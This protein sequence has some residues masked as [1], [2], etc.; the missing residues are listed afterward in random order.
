MSIS[1][2]RII[3]YK[4]FTKNI[5]GSSV[6]LQVGEK[7]DDLSVSLNNQKTFNLWQN[8]MKN[9][10]DKL[11]PYCINENIISLSEQITKNCIRKWAAVEIDPECECKSESLKKLTLHGEYFG[12]IHS[13]T[14]MQFNKVLQEAMDYLINNNIQIDFNRSRLEIMHRN[15]SPED[16]ASKEEFYIPIINR[17]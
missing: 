10:Y 14:A 17:V 8:F 4:T 13:G 2:L 7:L 6:E 16:P 5:I 11:I 1:K 15:Y 12:F 3:G 9:N